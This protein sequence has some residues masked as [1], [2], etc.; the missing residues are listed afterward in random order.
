MNALLR[1]NRELS[2]I[3]KVSQELTTSF[4]LEENMLSAMQILGTLLEMQR[5][6][7]FFWI[8]TPIN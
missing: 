6:C 1:K 8:R 7:V 4:N 5:G 2:A 3:L